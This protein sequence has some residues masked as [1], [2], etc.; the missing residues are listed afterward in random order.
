[1]ETVSNCRD[2]T[3]VHHPTMKS[4]VRILNQEVNP[5]PPPL[6]ILSKLISMTKKPARCAKCTVCFIRLVFPMPEGP[7]MSMTAPVPD[8]STAVCHIVEPSRCLSTNAYSAV[9]TSCT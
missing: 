9:S 7:S 3:I 5:P 8:G 4:L 6:P 2:S 1:M